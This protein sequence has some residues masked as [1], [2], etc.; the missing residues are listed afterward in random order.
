MGVSKNRGKIMENPM[1]KW[2]IWGGKNHPYFWWT[3]THIPTNRPMDPNNQGFFG[4]GKFTT[5]PRHFTCGEEGFV[6]AMEVGVKQWMFNGRMVTQKWRQVVPSCKAWMA[7]SC[8]KKDRDVL[9]PQENSY[10]H[11]L[12]IE[13]LVRI[14]RV[15]CKA[16]PRD[17]GDDIFPQC[18]RWLESKFEGG[19]NSKWFPRSPLFL[20]KQG[21]VTIQRCSFKKQFSPYKVPLV[22]V[23]FSRGF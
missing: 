2:M 13:N 20:F 17:W 14:C 12:S 11:L 6:E 19:Q 21:A 22:L 9:R 1:N 7:W 16:V 10:S 8:P 23:C 3:N 15:Y 18:W 5:F 4:Q